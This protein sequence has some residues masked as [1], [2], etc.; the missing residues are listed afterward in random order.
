MSW[1]FHLCTLRTWRH[2]TV[3]TPEFIDQIDELILEDSPISTNSIA[4]QLG[5]SRERV[6]PIIHEDLDC[7]SSPWS[8]PKMPERQQCQSSQQSLE[9]FSAMRDRN[10][11][12]LQLVTMDEIWLYHYVPETKHQ[13]M[14]CKNPL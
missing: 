6:L 8:G 7:G 11:F 9:F 14:D 13:T 2:K 4:E 3:T 12:L 1:Y 10:E 5:N